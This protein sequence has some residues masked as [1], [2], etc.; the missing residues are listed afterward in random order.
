MGV[1]QSPRLEHGA[2]KLI[3]LTE[4]LFLGKGAHKAVY[5]HPNDE[6]LCIKIAFK[7]PDEDINKEMRYRAVLGEKAE[8]MSLLVKYYGT[9]E[10]NM[11]QGFLFERVS[12]FDGA[13]CINLAQYIQQAPP[14]EE[15][16]RLMLDFREEF[17]RGRYVVAG[18]NIENFLVQRTSQNQRCIRIVDDLGTGAYIPVLYY[19][20]KLLLRRAVKYWRL[21]IHQ[22]VAKY[23]GAVTQE[24]ACCLMEKIPP[25]HIGLLS[26]KGAAA[27]KIG[28][29]LAGMGNHVTLMTT[30]A[31]VSENKNTG[32]SQKK[33][34]VVLLHKSLCW[35]EC[36]ARLMTTHWRTDV[37]LLDGLPG[38]AVPA[39]F[40]AKLFDKPVTVLVKDKELR[41]FSGTG[42]GVRFLRM[43]R[44]FV[45]CDESVKQH[46]SS[47]YGI[48]S[49]YL[50]VLPHEAYSIEK[51]SP[52]IAPESMPYLQ[53]LLHGDF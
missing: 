10:T 32:S 1:Y 7:V 34:S 5:A 52:R 36:L 48:R 33:A 37:L 38:F 25:M 23:S 27:A 15:L 51:G 49:K 46:I 22:L 20:D 16:M 14:Q 35:F 11:G 44:S 45:V 53:L 29:I 9:V 26:E 4:E 40:F 24:M 18:T 39:V 21:L 31:K 28:D 17:F 2:N 3:N 19:F 42:L 47:K 13:G 41:T 8:G 12:D 50:F 30:S 6:R 43:C